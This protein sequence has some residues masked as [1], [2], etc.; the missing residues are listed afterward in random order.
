M[1]ISL[2]RQSLS[3]LF[4]WFQG[5]LDA[6]CLRIPSRSKTYILMQ[7]YCDIC[8]YIQC[9]IALFGRPHF[10]I[11]ST[12]W[13]VAVVLIH[14]CNGRICCDPFC[15]VA[16]KTLVKWPDILIL[17]HLSDGDRNSPSS[18]YF[19]RKWRRTLAVQIHWS[20]TIF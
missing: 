12:Y 13:D 15:S 1:L 10:A 4:L 7:Y 2:C 20:P 9:H 11:Q 19:L 3:N 8:Y 17:S 6:K 14:F 16:D 5:F 18:S